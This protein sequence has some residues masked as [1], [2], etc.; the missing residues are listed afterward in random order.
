MH[1][2]ESFACKLLGL[3]FFLFFRIYIYIKDTTKSKAQAQKTIYLT[4]HTTYY[5]YGMR[6]FYILFDLN[7]LARFLDKFKSKS[8]KKELGQWNVIRLPTKNIQN[9][10]T[11]L[12]A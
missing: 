7:L 2:S 9:E 12:E 3:R 4:Y 6:K 8:C 5:L 11:D 1:L 10:D